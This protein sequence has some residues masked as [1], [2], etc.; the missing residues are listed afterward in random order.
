VLHISHE[1]EPSVVKSR[2]DH[3]LPA[4]TGDDSGWSHF[5]YDEAGQ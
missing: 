2:A 5:F 1:V 4:G 3:P